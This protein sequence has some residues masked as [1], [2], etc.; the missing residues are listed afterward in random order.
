[1][2]LKEFKKW[3]DVSGNTEQWLEHSYYSFA[4]GKYEFIYTYQ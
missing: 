2:G 3:D 1:M 4:K